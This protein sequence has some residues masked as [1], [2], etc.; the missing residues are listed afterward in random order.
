MIVFFSSEL[1]MCI[2]HCKEFLELT[3]W[4]WLVVNPLFI[5]SDKRLMHETSAK[6]NLYGW[7]MAWLKRRWFRS[8]FAKL[9]N[10]AFYA[11]V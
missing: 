11:T 2:G 9:L 3:L 6:E 10:V 1:I 7:K 5:R 4:G 8:S